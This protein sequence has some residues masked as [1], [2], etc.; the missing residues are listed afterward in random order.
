[1]LIPHGMG[2]EVSVQSASRNVGADL[3][4]LTIGR[5]I[6]TAIWWEMR[7]HA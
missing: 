7:L 3:L 1:M 4:A 2:E 5:Y 6:T